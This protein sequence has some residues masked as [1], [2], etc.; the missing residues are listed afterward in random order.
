MARMMEQ[1]GFF[2]CY[3]EHRTLWL[4]MDLRE[5]LGGY[6]EIL[7]LA[8]IYHI[9]SLATEENNR[10]GLKSKPANY[11]IDFGPKAGGMRA[12]RVCRVKVNDEIR[13]S[14]HVKTHH[15]GGS[16]SESKASAAPNL[17]E[18]FGYVVLHLIDMG[19]FPHFF[20]PPEG[21]SPK[22]ALYI[23]T[24]E[25][26]N[27]EL[28]YNL[29]EPRLIGAITDRVAMGIHLLN[30]IFLFGDVHDKNCGLKDGRPVIFDIVAREDI[31]ERHCRS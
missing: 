13:L 17:R 21:Y 23:A 11:R 29:Q 27:L 31:G 7:K 30:C 22:W 28:M 24:E 8:T 4:E 10:Y 1:K 26:E 18:V 9:G 6:G 25:I 15:A 2:N 19:P 5:Y 16:K 14:L 3:P 12:G 20:G